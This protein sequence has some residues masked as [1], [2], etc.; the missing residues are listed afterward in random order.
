MFTKRKY[1]FFIIRKSCK[2]DVLTDTYLSYG[3][4]SNFKVVCRL[5]IVWLVAT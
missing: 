5:S 4:I 3:K 1:L 2:L